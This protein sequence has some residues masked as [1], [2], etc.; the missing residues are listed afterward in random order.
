MRAWRS[1]EGMLIEEGPGGVPVVTSL[2]EELP[3]GAWK[4]RNHYTLIDEQG[5]LRSRYVVS[6]WSDCDDLGVSLHA[7]V[8]GELRELTVIWHTAGEYKVRKKE[9]VVLGGLQEIDAGDAEAWKRIREAFAAD[10]ERAVREAED[11]SRERAARV[12]SLDGALQDFGAGSEFR[13]AQEL[14]RERI[15]S[16]GGKLEMELLRALGR[17]GELHRS[18]G[19]SIRPA[20]E[21]FVRACRRAAFDATLRVKKPKAASKARTASE[22]KDVR[23]LAKTLEGLRKDLLKNAE[24]QE[25]ADANQ[26]A[27][28][29]YKAA[30]HVARAVG[31]LT[32]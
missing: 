10:R 26:S 29:Y 20:L 7:V 18:L 23:A 32:G 4:D 16:Q 19:K 15:A 5:K 31:Q 2:E 22:G 8:G 3:G 9:A 13:R 25:M 24:E 27:A 21:E 1:S 28:E 30:D 11:W 6:T 14:L 17:F 12:A